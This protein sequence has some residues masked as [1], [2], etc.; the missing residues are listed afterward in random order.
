MKIKYRPE[1][2]GLRAI[3]V[4]A[5]ILYHSKVSFLDFNLF[6]GGFIGVD[7][8]FVISGYLI[9]S[10]I[11]K[12]IFFTGNFSF[13]YFYER[14]IRRI[15][16]VLFFVML[17][18]LPLAWFIILPNS[19]VD[20]S[21]S[22]L[23]SIGFGSNFYFHYSGLEYG[24]IDSF[25]KPFLHTWSLSVEE[26][27]YI[28]FP[29]IIFVIFKISR[30]L[31][32]PLILTG[33]F[34]SLIFANWLSLHQPSL[35]FYMLP[36]RGWELLTGSL[37]SY[38]ELKYNRLKKNDY[39]NS[40]F[41]GLGLFLIFSSIIFFNDRMFHPSF[42]T[43]IPI[44][45]VSLII[46]YSNKDEFFTK[47]ISSKLFVSTGLISYSLYL[48][49]YPIF[50]FIR[51]SEYQLT[52]T[53]KLLI[54]LFIIIISIISYFLIEKPA[55]NKKTNFKIILSQIIFALI[56]LVVFNY[57]AI[58]NKGFKER[59]HFL[60]IMSSLDNNFNLR[61]IKQN[62][63]KCHDRL[64]DNG[65]CVFNELDNN[66]A[67]IIIL[68]DSLADSLLKDFISR[69]ENTKI[70]IIHMSYSSNLYLPNFVR[71]DTKNKLY[72]DEK[73]H[74]YRKNYFDTHK[75]RN[76]YIIFYG[77]YNWYLGKR[78]KFNKKNEIIEYQTYEKF[79]EK[80]KL[81]LSISE[82]NQNLKNK[83]KESLIE[84]SKN[85]KILLIYPTPVSPKS[86]R[87]RIKENFFN[88]KYHQNENF[89]LLDTVNYKKDIFIK[90]NEEITNFFNSLDIPN[91]FKIKT[92]DIF[93]PLDKCIFYDSN[94]VYFND[95]VHL[96]LE[97]SKK[98]NKRILDKII[99][100]ENKK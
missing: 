19:L 37:L 70:R 12:E 83:I 1:I 35:S 10:I 88:K 27:Y 36:S 60:K 6:Q 53:I 69:I 73:V 98:I 97:G 87:D 57:L 8:F 32:M 94:F 45:G 96:T 78:L 61:N 63:I 26:Q 44:I 86:I 95:A 92:D 48:W 3:A 21:K 62:G 14:R 74:E 17:V 2:D 25:L 47:V 52:S 7:I 38:W 75:N 67:D 39:S 41:T 13:R 33:L 93:C 11:L 31:L 65:F 40:L 54:P 90:Y 15:I 50:S 56:L 28:I 29:L 91:L 89:Y 76:S 77:D 16:P 58:I 22:L 100:L 51:I 4:I 81:D 20:F 49:H 64:G 99:E 30:S 23:Y 84:L 82:R 34:L 55:R 59:P 46:W 9:T 79:A 80:G 72:L 43:L 85:N 66:Q 68:G 5:V 42:I 71:Y 18:S 24:A